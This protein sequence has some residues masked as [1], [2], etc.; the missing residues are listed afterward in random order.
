[1]ERSLARK[2]LTT[3]S[4]APLPPQ[5][6]QPSFKPTGPLLFEADYLELAFKH[7]DLRL[8]PHIKKL[9]EARW[10][11]RTDLI[12]LASNVLGKKRILLSKERS[13]FIELLQKFPSPPSI[14]EKLEQDSPYIHPVTNKLTFYYRPLFTLENLKGSRRN[15]IIDPRGWFKSTLNTFSHSIQ[16]IIN[17]PSIAIATVQSSVPKAQDNAK[18]IRDVFKYNALFREL[19]PEHCPQN[20]IESFGTSTKFT[21]LARPQSENRKERTIEALSIE[22]YVSGYHFDILK[23]ADIVEEAN[24]TFET[25]RNL[26]FHQFGQFFNIL[27]APASQYWMDVE[28]TRYHEDETYGRIIKQELELP[29]EERTWVIHVRGC[30]R[31]KSPSGEPLKYTIDELEYDD[32]VDENGNR[33][34]NYPE[35]ESVEALQK[36]ERTPPMTPALF[37][38]QKKCNPLDYD[39]TDKPFPLKYLNIMTLKQYELLAETKLLSQVEVAVDTAET[40]TSTSCE[41]AIIVCQWTTTNKAI[42]RDIRHGKYTALELLENLYYVYRVYKP[43]RYYLERTGY[44]AGLEALFTERTRT[45]PHK[46]PPLPIKWIDRS[47]RQDKDARIMANL[48]PFYLSG[49][50]NVIDTVPGLDALKK[51]LSGFP[52]LRGKD[53]IDPLSDL[54]I[55]R[56]YILNQPPEEILSERSQT[57]KFFYASDEEKLE[58][59]FSTIGS[60]FCDY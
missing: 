2:S 48:Q 24:S 56:Q 55:N 39:D 54:F 35:L 20:N 47:K 59:P 8:Q 25:G 29:P 31:K 30:Y 51:Q 17:F 36:L 22:S 50:L 53:I 12:W 11:A 18:E 33:E 49:N 41:N 46:Y 23:F 3:P 58:G 5:P 43:T 34:S 44:N 38:C 28:G 32:Y 10:M 14:E 7:R 13:P 16:W 6:K 15:L 19:F 26:I 1:M 9:C 57:Y 60:S 52:K 40:Q 27:K 21:T 37:A 4:Y 42:L 45:Q